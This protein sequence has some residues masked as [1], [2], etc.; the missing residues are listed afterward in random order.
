M[1]MVAL[2]LLLDEPLLDVAAA[3]AL[4]DPDELLLELL[5]LPQPAATSAVSAAA[6]NV[7]RT[8]MAC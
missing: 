3:A 7:T 8:F 5:E 2:Q 6:T 4:D 1:A